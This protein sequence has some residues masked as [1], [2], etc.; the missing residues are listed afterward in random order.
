MY[1]YRREYPDLSPP[2][3][4]P[5]QHIDMIQF[6]WTQIYGS[7]G[8]KKWPYNQLKYM[9]IIAY[10]W[11]GYPLPSPPQGREHKQSKV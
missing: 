11:R 8:I 1:I 5:L 7:E 4:P 10:F 9:T 2:S 6:F 3:P